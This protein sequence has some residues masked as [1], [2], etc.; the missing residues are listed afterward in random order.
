MKGKACRLTA[1]ARLGLGVLG[2]LFSLCLCFP[3]AGHL[4][5]FGDLAADQAP[6]SLLRQGSGSDERL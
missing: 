4:P 6:L 3:L 1:G 5:S 2:K